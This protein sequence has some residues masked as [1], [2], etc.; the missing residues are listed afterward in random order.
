MVFEE[1]IESSDFLELIVSPT[2]AT[3][4]NLDGIVMDFSFGLKGRRNLNVF[5]RVDKTGA[6][7]AISEGESGEI[8][9]RIFRECAQRNARV[10]LKNHGK[11]V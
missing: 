10:N 6:E 4:L 5:I 7:D 3:Q 8:E 9:G 11:Y 1:D 2:E